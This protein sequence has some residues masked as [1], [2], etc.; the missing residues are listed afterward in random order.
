MDNELFRKLKKDYGL[1]FGYGSEIPS[2][3]KL[4]TGSLAIDIALRGGIP[5]SRVTVINGRESTGKTALAYHIIAEAQKKYPN[6][7][8]GFISIEGMNREWAGINGVDLSRLFIAEPDRGDT[9]VDIFEALLATRDFSVL[10]LDSIGALA[11]AGELDHEAS[12]G[13]MGERVKLVKKLC[14][15][16][17]ARL[18][19]DK[20]TRNDCACIFIN[21]I[22]L[23]MKG[24]TQIAGGQALRYATALMLT[25]SKG[26]Y[27]TD[28]PLKAEERVDNEKHQKIGLSVNAQIIKNKVDAES[29]EFSYKF[30]NRDGLNGRA[31]AGNFDN[32]DA[33]I[34]EA[35]KLDLIQKGGA[36]YTLPTGEKL[37]G[38]ENVYTSL[39]GNKELLD[40]L[41]K[42]VLEKYDLCN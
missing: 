34:G 26:D 35:I 9:A 28:P 10:V 16:V 42:V 7:E 1:K 30:Y 39:I 4:R 29:K 17:T 3:E 2:V 32:T 14:N 22:Y 18:Q 20:E 37:Q 38:R 15:K 6:K 12:Y 24:Y 23:D 36:W 40:S 13:A 25:L 8:T 11:P 21:H 33:I 41:E 31:I 19:P 5:K 27:L